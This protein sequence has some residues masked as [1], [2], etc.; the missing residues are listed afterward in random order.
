ME[1]WILSK[2][3][4]KLRL[5]HFSSLTTGDMD[6]R[7]NVPLHTHILQPLSRDHHIETNCLLVN[8][9]SKFI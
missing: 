2:E 3:S 4:G 7:T 1:I 8:L 6:T 5:S 9:D